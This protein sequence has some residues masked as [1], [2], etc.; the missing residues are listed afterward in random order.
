M[1][2]NGKDL[3]IYLE[4]FIVTGNLEVDNEIGVCSEIRCY[5]IRLVDVSFKTRSWI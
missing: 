1:N 4:L 2:K 3:N 5:W